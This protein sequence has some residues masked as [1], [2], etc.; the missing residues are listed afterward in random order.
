MILFDVQRCICGNETH[1]AEYGIR[2]ASCTNPLAE[3]TTDVA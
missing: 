3:A 2:G 1:A